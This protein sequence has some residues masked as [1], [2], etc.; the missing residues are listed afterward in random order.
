M[1]RAELR[2]QVYELTGRPS[3]YAR[4]STTQIDEY[5]NEGMMRLAQ[6]TLPPSLI[7]FVTIATA[8]G[9]SVYEVT[10]N[11]LRI[12]SIV[13]GGVVLEPTTLQRL[14]AA[15]PGWQSASTGTPTHWLPLGRGATGY[16]QYKLY[17]TPSAVANATVG[18]LKKPGAL[19]TSGEILEWDE[20]EQ[21][22]LAYYGAWRHLQC[23]TEAD[24]D[25]HADK[26]LAN[27]NAIVDMYRRNNSVDSVNSQTAGYETGWRTSA[28]QGG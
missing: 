16:L 20:L 21:Y 8:N 17:P 5:I 26:M 11:P 3:T 4:L 25:G 18:V 14:Y 2:T 24:Q 27:F 6:E 13:Y 7:D 12:T 23:K 15:V 10:G 1:T 28:P 22:A 19:P 9:T